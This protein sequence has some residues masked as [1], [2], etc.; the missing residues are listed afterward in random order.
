MKTFLLTIFLTG[1]TLFAAEDWRPLFNGRDLSGWIPVQVAP[2]TFTVRDGIIVST[3]IPTGVMRTDK[4]YENFEL[5]LEWKHIVPQGNA[6]LFVWSYPITAPGQ[7]FT[8]SI[9]VQI[10]D[11]RNSETYTSHGDIFSIHGARMKPDRP[12]P[13]GSE[14]CLPSEF[15]CKPAGE[16]NHY[17][18]V[19]NNGVVKLSVNGKEV[20]GGSECTPRKGYI[21]LESEGTECHFRNIRIKELP[22]TNPKP[23]EVAPLADNTVSIYN[24]L[25]LDGWQSTPEIEKHWKAKDWILEHDG[26]SDGAA[27]PLWTLK[28]Y[29]DFLMICDWRP[30]DKAKAAEGIGLKVRGSDKEIRIAG[31]KPDGTWNRSIITVRGNTL[32]TELNG[33][34]VPEKIELPGARGEGPIALQHRDYPMQ[35]ANIYIKELS[36]E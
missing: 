33:I 17:R 31:G 20:S 19:C 21:C 11:G 25:N 13:R 4:Q 5:E 6:G 27:A 29:A 24:G 16:W 30:K 23:E 35:F 32:T 2:N 7:P 26:Q 22:S 3:G 36:G 10:L 34:P 15:R 28:S 9:E 18:V 12:H 14:R 1:L 8:R